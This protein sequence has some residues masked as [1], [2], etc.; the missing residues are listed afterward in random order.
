[1]AV[2][3]YMLDRLNYVVPKLNTYTWT[4]EARCPNQENAGHWAS[5]SLDRLYDEVK[6]GY[7]ITRD[8]SELLHDP[9]TRWPVICEYCNAPIDPLFAHHQVHHERIWVRR[10]TQEEIFLHDAPAGAMWFAP[11]F[12]DTWKPQLDHVLC[13]RTPGRQA[14]WIVDSQ[15][16]N[17]TLPDD[18]HMEQH[19]CWV[20]SGT[21][22]DLPNITVGKGG[23]T[24]SAGAG[25]VQ[26]HS[27][28]GF[29]RD[30]WLVE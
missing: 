5:V 14:E 20:I 21:T 28:H 3:C 17:C 15:A 25:S 4:S 16:S 27:W 24:C 26:T 7:S 6:Y 11:W 2:Q 22:A 19:H 29:L 13:V 10:D 23:P 12:D 18:K 30:G 1:M 8:D 9:Q